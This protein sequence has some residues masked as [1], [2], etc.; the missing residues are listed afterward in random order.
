MQVSQDISFREL[1]DSRTNRARLN[2][3]SLHF[4]WYVN[5][6]EDVGGFM[7]SVQNITTGVKLKEVA[8]PYTARYHEFEDITRG[9]HYVCVGAVDSVGKARVL[10]RGQCREFTAGRAGEREISNV[11]LTTVLV[12]FTLLITHS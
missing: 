11:W 4:A 1:T 3:K 7:V 8:L 5:T 9:Q 12:L 10:Q 2:A 6:H